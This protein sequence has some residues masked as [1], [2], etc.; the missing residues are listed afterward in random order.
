M[1]D[2]GDCPDFSE[3]DAEFWFPGLLKTQ[4]F[5]MLVVVLRALGS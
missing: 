5:T 4:S 1:G 3:M 2:D